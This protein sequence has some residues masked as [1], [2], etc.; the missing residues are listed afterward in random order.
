MGIAGTTFVLDS[1]ASLHLNTTIGALK[2]RLSMLTTR[3][4]TLHIY[5]HRLNLPDSLSAEK[6]TGSAWHKTH[7]SHLPVTCARASRPISLSFLK[8]LYCTHILTYLLTPTFLPLSEFFLSLYVFFQTF[9][10][11]YLLVS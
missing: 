1:P 10:I 2:I 9:V 3:G 5:T 7:T 11:L 8:M 4:G 6:D